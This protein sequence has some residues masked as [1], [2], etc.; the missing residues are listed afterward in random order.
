MLKRLG[1]SGREMAQFLRLKDARS[2]RGYED[3]RRKI[4]LPPLKRL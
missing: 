1:L 3:G 2:V 4:G